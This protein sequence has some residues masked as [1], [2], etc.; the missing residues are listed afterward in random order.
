MLVNLTCYA[1][2]HLIVEPYAALT[3]DSS[4]VVSG[5][6][7]QDLTNRLLFDGGIDLHWHRHQFFYQL[8]GAA[9]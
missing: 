9:R 3:V 2:Q 6:L 4:Q 1:E 5:G 8:S 7:K